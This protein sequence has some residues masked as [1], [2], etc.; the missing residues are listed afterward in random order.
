MKIIQH[1]NTQ[2]V[3]VIDS[4]FSNFDFRHAKTFIELE[5][6]LF[7][8]RTL[9]MI[10]QFC[11]CFKLFW[12]VFFSTFSIDRY[13]YNKKNFWFYVMEK[14]R[15]EGDQICW[16]RCMKTFEAVPYNFAS[17]SENC[18]L[19]WVRLTP[20]TSYSLF[21]FV[22]VWRTHCEPLNGHTTSACF[23]SYIYTTI[24]SNR[25][26]WLSLRFSMYLIHL[27]NDQIQRYFLKLTLMSV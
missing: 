21:S 20:M 23:H 9:S 18:N 24:S 7:P 14:M 17:I 22:C 10:S 6:E 4:F 1:T 15:D 8:I 12:S 2:A 13:F 19:V 25:V 3:A 11:E 5:F 26:S 27:A 16:Y